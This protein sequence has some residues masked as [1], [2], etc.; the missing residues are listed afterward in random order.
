MSNGWCWDNWPCSR[1][2]QL[3][4]AAQL[5]MAV[6]EFSAA[7]AVAG[8]D[9]RAKKY[10]AVADGMVAKF[11]AQVPL[12]SGSLGV[13]SSSMILN[14]VGLA[15]SDEAAALIATYLNDAT[16]ICSW[17]P[18]NSFWILQGLGN[19]GSLDRAAEMAAL[20]WGGMTRLAPGCMWELFS[21]M[22]EPLLMPG[23]KAPTR[24]SY[25]R[26]YRRPNPAQA[27]FPTT[28]PSLNPASITICAP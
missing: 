21:P 25:C 8:D 7:L 10:F 15:T 2:T 24:P 11:R 27:T 23:G 16:S 20:C 28:D 6:R 5:L 12:T 3:T 9:A 22:W 18:F 1:E 13:H 26:M 17:S 4:F 19:A 14:A